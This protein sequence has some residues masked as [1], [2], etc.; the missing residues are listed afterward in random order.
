[1]AIFET[2]WVGAT[3]FI[4]PQQIII[5]QT[6]LHFTNI[7]INHSKSSQLYSA[8]AQC[9]YYGSHNT[10]FLLVAGNGVWS[11]LFYTK[12]V[13]A[14]GHE[15]EI[16][17]VLSFSDC[18]VLSHTVHDCRK[19]RIKI[20]IFGDHEKGQPSFFIIVLDGLISFF[21]SAV[22]LPFLHLYF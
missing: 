20:V 1:M 11:L 4:M 21:L 13:E 3:S 22:F 5:N 8:S 18:Y 14:F 9:F 15:F 19:L 6:Y 17:L 2:P 10:A 7:T 16:L 12:V